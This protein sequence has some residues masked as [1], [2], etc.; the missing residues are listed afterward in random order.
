MI[1][2]DLKLE[3]QLFLLALQFMTRL[4]VPAGLPYSDDLSVRSAKYYPAV[5]IVVGAIGAA[6]LFLASLVLPLPVA[7]LLS[8]A[9]TLLI[10]GA[11]HEDGLADTADGLGGGGSPERTLDI[12]RDSRIGVFGFVTL[13]MVLALKAAALMSMPPAMAAILLVAGHGLSRMA[14]VHIIATTRYARPSGTK[15]AAP[16]ITSDGYRWAFSTSLLIL[17]ALLLGSGI[18]VAFFAILGCIALAQV[19]RLMFLRRLGGYTGDCLGG[20]QQMG[21]LG[22]YLGALLWL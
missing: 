6:V 8:M 5:G 13:G 10:T 7:V 12:M 20:I 16:S 11:M 19:L 21:E 3:A 18:G 4:P 2:E 17:I 22:V 15:F 14:T 9:A 1:R